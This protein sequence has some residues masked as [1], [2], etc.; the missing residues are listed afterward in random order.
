VD[1][2][3]PKV[4]V[5]NRM[6]IVVEPVHD[7]VVIKG[8]AGSVGDAAGEGPDEHARFAAYLSDLLGPSPVSERDVLAGIV[9]DP[10]HLM[11]DAVLVR[12]IERAATE[13]VS[14]E[15]FRAWLEGQEPALSTFEFARRRAGEWRFLPDHIAGLSPD[16]WE[17][18]TA[19]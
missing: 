18:V 4:V 14:A 12:W 2:G 10:D 13:A 15:R 11:A 1:R 16:S 6:T 3:T 8:G 17:P 7:R 19:R 5:V 9:A